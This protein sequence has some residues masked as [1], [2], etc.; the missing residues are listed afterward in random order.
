MQGDLKKH[1]VLTGALVVML[2][3]TVI[4]GMIAF[5]KIGYSIGNKKAAEA[6]EKIE[7]Y[8][9]LQDYMGLSGYLEKNEF[10]ASYDE[11]ENYELILRANRI[12]GNAVL[13]LESIIYPTA[14]TDIQKQIE[15]YVDDLNYFLDMEF[16]KYSE[17]YDMDDELNLNAYEGMLN[18]LGAMTKLVFHL[19]DE[20][21][22][23]VVKSSDIERGNLLT[24]AYYG[25]R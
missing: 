15:Y 12:Y 2:I 9:A 22:Q 19:T 24:E 20:E 17:W 14:Y 21:W 13:D 1:F 25:S 10:Y 8:A 4:Y 23:T 5:D 6:S 18:E 16:Q 7:E 11:L 3:I